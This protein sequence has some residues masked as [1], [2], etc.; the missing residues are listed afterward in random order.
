MFSKTR[1]GTF[2]LP[3]YVRPCS[4][5]KRLRL[6][7]ALKCLL[8][9]SKPGVDRED[10]ENSEETEDEGTLSAE[11]VYGETHKRLEEEYTL[12]QI[13]TSNFWAEAE[14]LKYFE[15]F[16]LKCLSL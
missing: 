12:F 3:R 8:S 4:H 13:G 16:C 11:Q 1:V 7:C 6:N 2:L 5:S 15:D 10:G 14:S 9:S